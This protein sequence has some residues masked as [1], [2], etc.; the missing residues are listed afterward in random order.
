[1]FIKVSLICPQNMI[2]TSENASES[3]HITNQR[4]QRV[5]HV[6][7]E[8]WLQEG[9]HRHSHRHTD[10]RPFMTL[11]GNFHHREGKGK[12]NKSLFVE[13]QHTYL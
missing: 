2:R 5:V 11:S 10:S 13:I 1:M 8:I 12:E 4:M 7:Y 6:C 9:A 3:K